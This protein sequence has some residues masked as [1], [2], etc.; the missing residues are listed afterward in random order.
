MKALIG[1]IFTVLAL[2]VWADPTQGITYIT[3]EF[4]PYNFKG[5]GGEA[6]G[7]NTDILVA[8]LEKL[9]SS[10]ARK[11]IKIQP[12]VRGYR[13]TQEPGNLNVL[14]STTRTKKREGLFKWVGPLSK[15]SNDLIVLKGNPKKVMV[16]S[17]ED[18]K[19]FKYAAIRD[20]LGELL[21]KEKGVPKKNISQST[22]FFAMIKKLQDGKVDAISYN[23]TV[24]KW[25]I[26][27]EGL[28]PADFESAVSTP[29]GE[30]YFAF[31]KTIDDEVVKA[32]QK[33]LEEV[34]ADTTFV[35]SVQDKYLK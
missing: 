8:M 29:I 32:H 20:D 28:S 25:L 11:D 6:V 5:E 9:K 31:N 7:M 33:A 34:M 24:A 13:T 17:P 35:Q 1:L 14:Y 22:N 2:P 30:H 4:P 16:N 12:W 3:E 18:Y 27:K 15:G 21:L 26:K 19:K 23:G 10:Q